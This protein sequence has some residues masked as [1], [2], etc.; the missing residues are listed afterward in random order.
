MSNACSTLRFSRYNEVVCNIYLQ[1]NNCGTTIELEKNSINQLNNR[2][3]SM[4]IPNVIT[5]RLIC[6]CIVF[7]FLSNFK[8]FLAC[9][10]FSIT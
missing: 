5:Y 6:N 4:V 8:K 2:R 10:V 9:T 7:V 3:N 1:I